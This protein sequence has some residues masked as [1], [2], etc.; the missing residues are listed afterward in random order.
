MSENLEEKRRIL[1]A[2]DE[3]AMRN[4]FQRLFSNKYQVDV[5]E[6][7]DMGLK[8]LKENGYDLLITDIRMP[9]GSGLDL[10]AAAKSLQAGIEVVMITGA[11]ALETA[12]ESLRLGAYDY[13]TKPFDDID[14]VTA[15]VEKALEKQWLTRENLRLISELE[16]R[17]EIFR[18]LYQVSISA[19]QDRPADEVFK[20]L[21]AL[22]VSAR[23]FD[24]SAL[25]LTNKGQTMLDLN[26]VAYSRE[27]MSFGFKDKER[28]ALPLNANDNDVVRVALNGEVFVN[29]GPN[30]DLSPRLRASF[31]CEGK[32]LQSVAAT[33]VRATQA[34]KGVLLAGSFSRSGSIS[35]EMLDFLNAHATYLGL[36]LE[37]FSLQEFLK[38]EAIT[39]GLTGIYNY[40]YFR[41][42]IKEETD[43]SKRYGQPFSLLLIDID[44]L[45]TYNDTH[46]HLRGDE[47]IREVSNLIKNNSR[48]VDLVARYGGDEFVIILPKATTQEAYSQGER[49]R[50]LIEATKFKGASI[51]PGGKVTVSGGLASFPEAGTTINE[52]VDNTDAALYQAKQSGRNRI[53]SY[54]PIKTSANRG[55]D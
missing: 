8:K 29:N 47:L 54:T 18:G 22:I 36:I 2:E 55:D 20:E 30:L 10:L 12:I 45:K 3:E 40:R 31:T 52:L 51:L 26:L 15:V 39:D 46:G 43:R 48:S 37:H 17:H 44:C 38:R 16:M 5:A 9:K 7:V 25:F 19:F 34:I 1:V 23:Y 24:L 50:K 35:K 13:L 6:N 4:L 28:E 53:I 33:P 21:L 32:T 41:E 49:V 42:K 11:A 27:N 14:K